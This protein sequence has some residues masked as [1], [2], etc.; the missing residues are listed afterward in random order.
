MKLW[1]KIK[2]VTI[3]SLRLRSGN[4]KNS[5]NNPTRLVSEVEPSGAKTLAISIPVEQKTNNIG[6]QSSRDLP[7]TN[8]LPPFV[9]FLDVLEYLVTT[10]PDYSQVVKRTVNLGNTGYNVD[11]E[12]LGKAQIEK[13]R[14]EIDSFS[15]RIGKY[16]AGMDNFINI[17]FRQIL[18]KGAISLEVVPSEKMDR[19]ERVVIVPMKTVRFK[20]ENFEWLPYQTG[21]MEGEVLLNTNQ[22]VYA[23]LIQG[24]NS[25]YAI[26]PFLSALETTLIQK[27]SIKNVRSIITKFG[28]LGFL[29]AQKKMPLNDGL[30][31]SEYED[32]LIK[33]LEKLAE[34]FRQ[35]FSSGAAVAYDDVTVNHNSISTDTRGAIDLFELIEQQI[36]SGLDIDPALLGR[37]YSTTETYAGVVY[38][39][40]I[41]SLNNIR[42]LIK[43]TLEKIYFMHLVMQGFPV[44]RVK[45]T[46]N[47][48]KSLKPKEDLE[49]EQI[50]IA[51]VLAKMN[52]GIIDLDTAAR[53]LGYEKA[54]GTPQPIKQTGLSGKKYK[55]L[56]TGIQKF[57]E[58]LKDD[59]TLH[60]IKDKLL[61]K[62]T[63]EYKASQQALI[64]KVEALKNDANAKNTDPLSVKLPS[65]SPND[66][67]DAFT[68]V[69]EES[70][71][72]QIPQNIQDDYK[73]AIDEAWKLG[74]FQGVLES[75][76]AEALTKIATYDMGKTFSDAKDIFKQ[77]VS[78]VI[79]SGDR[80]TTFQELK[81][82]ILKTTDFEGSDDGEYAKKTKILD[83]ML[84]HY[85]NRSRNF[86]RVLAIYSVD[87]NASLEYVAIIDQKTSKICKNMNGRIITVDTAK[88]FVDEY[89]ST[90]D[91]ESVREKFD[92]SKNK[93]AED[94]ALSTDKLVEQMGVKLPPLHLGGCRTTV[95][96]KTDTVVKLESGNATGQ[97]SISDKAPK[98]SL[99]YIQERKK[100]L[101]TQLN[102]AERL[103]KIQAMQS[104][105]VWDE[106]NLQSHVDIKNSKGWNI[107]KE[108]YEKLSKNVLKNPDRIFT[109]NNENGFPK[110]GFYKVV[111]GTE[112]FSIIDPA[113]YQIDSLAKLNTEGYT[114][115]F[116]EIK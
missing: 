23:P 46:F 8:A 59:E 87:Q 78:D 84:G 6:M 96:I 4:A 74:Q 69:Y 10:T 41:S 44:K 38:H 62:L 51:N 33:E 75:S 111:D 55:S 2:N 66:I 116:L 28:L 81:D 58:I 11:F 57:D 48:N 104:G 115:K 3:S 27:D 102:K 16:N 21:V 100:E 32:K 50:R 91:A 7:F 45:V 34:S 101:T 43:R 36:A 29:F 103:N 108:D 53:E 67:V 17:L 13:A 79:T 47:P 72:T 76:Q 98:E 93:I 68:K 1:D 99:K 31:D 61:E 97:T 63:T 83:W 52:S 9:E 95:V 73:K 26:P 85:V 18:I 109:F 42:K 56:S 24:E 65:L 77:A 80:T 40:F 113:K 70:F 94:N 37:T 35:N 30:S 64:D 90:T 110:Y 82:K 15:S 25:P 39:A 112:Y 22:Y 106:S 5:E 88:K 49:A 105:S 71:Q 20:Y 14:N 12:G 89:I 54:T 107:K 19:V 114:D 86:S 60:K 92:Y